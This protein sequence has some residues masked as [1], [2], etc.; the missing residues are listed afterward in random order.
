MKF[1][2]QRDYVRC[3]TQ[4]GHSPVSQASKELGTMEVRKAKKL[5]E[6]AYFEDAEHLGP[7]GCFIPIS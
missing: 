5:L 1:P 7:P 3:L 4:D 2:Q 6:M